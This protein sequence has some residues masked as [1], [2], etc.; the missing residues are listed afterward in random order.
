MKN[1]IYFFLFFSTVFFSQN[2]NY[3]IEEPQK[4]TL[5]VLPV[6][7]NQLEEIEYFKAYL[8]PI[9]K[10]ATLIKGIKMSK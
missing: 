1:L 5:P 6:V 8:L 3:S 4:Q 2:Y 10:K 9:T 7:N